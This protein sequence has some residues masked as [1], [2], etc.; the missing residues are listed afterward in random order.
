M[1]P[2]SKTI[3]LF[4]S[5]K[6]W[7]G[8]EKW[9]YET[10]F[11]LA[12]R[13]Y[14]VYVYCHPK[15]EIFNRIQDS[16]IKT[17]KIRIFNL[18]FI[19]LILFCRLFFL[20]KKQGI[21]TIIFGLPSDVKAASTASKLAG[22]K[23]I[24]Y[25]RGTPLP[26]NNN[27]LNRFLFKH[28][29]TYIIANS[30]EVK[31]Q[32][33]LNNPNIISENKIK[34]LYNGVKINNSSFILQRNEE[35]LIGN[36]GRLSKEKGHKFLIDLA[37]ELKKE[38]L[39]FRIL[40]AGNGPLRKKLETEA[41]LKKVQ[42]KIIFLD[43]VENITEFLTKIDIFV[44]PS[45]HEGAANVLL[46]AM[47]MAKPV[48]AFNTSSLPEFIEHGQTGFLAEMGN[49]QQLTF[50]VCKLAKDIEL[51]KKIGMNALNEITGKYDDNIQFEKLLTLLN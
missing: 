33:L 15:G 29:L 47:A 32:I 26:V 46:E 44:L 50:Y 6:S 4:N 43:F 1:N 14:D 38:N 36:A 22:V 41:I 27:I 21:D 28:I 17:I 51:R 11:R 18:S 3:C 25:R 7:G 40:I 37:Q 48:V 8:G 30:D 10:A 2:Q 49:I 19:D 45:L 12:E 39:K 5:C 20:I 16:R 31:R 13:G 23:N 34:I 35:I 42:E 24:I 9:H